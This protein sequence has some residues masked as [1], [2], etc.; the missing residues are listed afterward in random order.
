M[1][2]YLDTETYSEKPIKYGV[3]SYAEAVEVMIITYAVDDNP[4]VAIDTTAGCELTELV[5]HFGGA[6][7]PFAQPAFTLPWENEI[8]L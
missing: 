7:M 2:L 6:A 3:H 8:S 5:W 1:I 4:V